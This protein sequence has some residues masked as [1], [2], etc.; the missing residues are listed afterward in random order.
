M[1]CQNFLPFDN[2]SLAEVLEMESKV[3]SN[4]VLQGI[5]GVK[6]CS[7]TVAYLQLLLIRTR[8]GYRTKN[9]LKTC[10]QFATPER[11]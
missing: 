5:K 3:Y 6:R 1:L 10:V 2:Q 4:P 8:R 7:E 11:I 9:D